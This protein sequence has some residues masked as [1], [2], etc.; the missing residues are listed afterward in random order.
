MQVLAVGF[1]GV[2]LF[3]A[4][5]LWL[6]ISNESPISFLDALF[7]ATTA[8]CV[9][10][11]VTITPAV[12]FTLFGKV[13]LLLLI[14]IGGLGVIAC[15]TAFFLILK[16]RIT[17]RE[18]IVIQEAYNM[19]KLGGMVV[20]VR[21]VIL[22]TFVVEGAGAL[23]YSLQFIPQFGLIKGIWYSV[24]HAISAFCNAG[25]DII[26][27]SSLKKYATNPLINITTMLLIILSGIGFLVW[28]DVI[29]NGRRIFRKEVPKKWWFTRL[30][31][32][33]K[34]AIITTVVLIIVG[35]VFV[36][37]LEYTNADTLGGMTFGEK[38]MASAFQSVTTRTAGFATISQSGL[39]TTTKLLCSILMFIGG[40]PG[41][42]A[43]GVKTT[44]IAMLVL[45]CMTYI[46][47]KKDTECFGRKISTENIRAG[48][49]VVMV[50][51]MVF[52]T[53]VVVITTIE[54][55]ETSFINIMYEVASA[56]ATVGL[57]AELTPNLTNI[58]QIV[59]IVL[60]Y[61][62]RLGPLTLALVLGGR[63]H[64]NEG[65]RELPERRILVG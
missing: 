37:V 9:T 51:F 53:G 46:K 25:I 54:P 62:G 23:L 28:N 55:V 64:K 6:P 44:T 38:I 13:I 14:Q 31:L 49:I 58:S 63:S 32:H 29:T 34:I 19:D 24:F 42:T 57:T 39:H 4:V 20:M 12:Q 65:K 61:I 50:S 45:T 15:G 5:L 33:S 18:R 10:G 26:G 43:G 36:F 27:D 48:I 17:V 60:M 1:L 56:V 16:K 21:R 2:I 8:V 41:G 3:G 47:G 11:L 52:I 40:S 59:L 22:G 35:T 30:T 7:T